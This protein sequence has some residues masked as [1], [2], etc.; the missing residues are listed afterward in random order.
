MQIKSDWANRVIADCPFFDF[1]IRDETLVTDTHIPVEIS[2]LTI[3]YEIIRAEQV[4]HCLEEPDV[5]AELQ[6]LS[7]IDSLIDDTPTVRNLL[8]VLSVLGYSDIVEDFEEQEIPEEEDNEWADM[9]SR[10]KHADR[11]VVKI[12][13]G[14]TIGEWYQASLKGAWYA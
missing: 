6:K 1:Q 14:T 2:K 7:E 11:F 4:I 8:E 3:G 12:L 13:D 5:V 10:H 9:E